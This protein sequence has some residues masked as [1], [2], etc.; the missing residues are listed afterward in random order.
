MSNRLTLTFL[1]IWA[2]L[3]GLPSGLVMGLFFL[4]Y[5]HGHKKGILP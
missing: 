3:G 4:V 2:L 5:E 1:T